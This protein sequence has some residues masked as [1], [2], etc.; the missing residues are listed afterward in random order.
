[1]LA[2]FR[3]PAY[4]WLW[5]SN[6][7]GSAGRWALVLVLG[8]Q[9]L[10]LTHSSFW[11]GLGLFLTQGPVILLAP[12]S[13]ALADR[14][15]RRMLNVLAAAMSAVTTFLFAFITWIGLMSLPVMLV[16]SVVFGVS[17][18]LQMT[19]RSTLVPGLVPPNSLLNAVSLFQV[20]TLGAQFL[21]PVLATPLLA[22]GGPHLAWSLCSLL[23]AAS[24]VLAV[25]VGDARVRTVSAERRHR[26]RAS[27]VYLRAR[28]LAWVAVW[29]VALHC[30]LTMAYQGMLPMFVSMDLRASVSTY[31]ILLTSIG[32]GA[33]IGSLGLAKF[34]GDHYRPR[35]FLV[36]L[37]GSGASLAVM[38][39]APSAGFAVI[40]GVF[41]GGS[42]AMFMAMILALIQGSVDNEFR[43]RA[44]SFYQMITLTP[45]AAIGWGMGG[46]ADL[47][48]PRPIMV[49][50]GILFLIAMAAFTI[51]SPWLRLLFKPG[52]WQQ[53][54][55][56]A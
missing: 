46:L 23:Y 21:G 8:A 22:I 5:V 16:L 42:Q 39:A 12:Y 54:A 6:V 55:Q 20:G 52:G 36:S 29:A 35:L 17:F 15:D 48:Q 43:G 49:V 51:L 32:F 26:L 27:L 53:S 11:V 38:G 44:T 40:T 47:E 2:S 56:A 1:M 3:Y 31:G 18:V 34:S 37:V 41:V 19:L 14:F 13:G 28:P 45:M 30:S 25:R 50:S 10:E 24:A 33:V 9:L 4:R 7:A